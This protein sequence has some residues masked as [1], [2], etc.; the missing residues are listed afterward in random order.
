ME[1]LVVK[2]AL[3]VVSIADD[4]FAVYDDVQSDGVV[5]LDIDQQA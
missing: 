1:T 3:V 2:L 5:Y 4:I